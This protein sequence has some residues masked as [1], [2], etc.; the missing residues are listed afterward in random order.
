MISMMVGSIIFNIPLEKCRSLQDAGLNGAVTGSFGF[1][2][3][4]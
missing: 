2:G 4:L 3:L 1:Y